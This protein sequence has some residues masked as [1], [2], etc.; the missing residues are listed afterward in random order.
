MPRVT[1]A[2]IIA[3]ALAFLVEMAGDG[4]LFTTFALWPVG[5]QFG[6]WQVV[7]YAFLHGSVSHLV[8]NM[9]GLYMFGQDLERV[10]G[11]QRY[12][13][14]YA[15]SVVSA[16]AVQLGFAAWSGSPFPT[17]GASGGVFGLLL[18][19]ALYF[20]QRRVMLLIPPIPM[21]AWL[22]ATLYGIIVSSCSASR[23]RPAA[24][25]TSRTSGACSAAICSSGTGELTAD[26][27]LSSAPASLAQA[28]QHAPFVRPTDP[29]IDASR[30]SASTFD[31]TTE[32]SVTV[33]VPRS[34][35]RKSTRRHANGSSDFGQQIHTE[36]PRRHG[37]D[38]AEEIVTSREPQDGLRLART[39]SV[40]RSLVHVGDLAA[41]FVIAAHRC[42]SAASTGRRSRA[43][44]SFEISWNQCRDG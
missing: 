30:K 36:E 7:T 42:P 8:F 29:L 10:W 6:P 2:L 26:D 3:N 5:P 9:F 35:K 40:S 15:V 33:P 20:P 43:R 18:A 31:L 19:F 28:T 17:V 24:S 41:H 13:L 11:P 37:A 21:P 16:G 23:A 12:L 27:A 14:Y 22:F 39:L 1:Q 32:S 44:P 25:R 34:T 4:V 38:Q